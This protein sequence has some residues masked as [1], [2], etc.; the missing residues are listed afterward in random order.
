M[1]KHNNV[2]PFQHFHKKWARRV[3]TWLHQPAQKRIRRERRKLRA[4]AIAPRPAAGALRPLVNCP[5]QKYNSKSR[6]GRGFTLDELK[7]AG[8]DPKYARTVGIAVDSR[9]TNKCGES[10]KLNVDRLQAYKSRLVVVKKGKATADVSQLKG[11]IL[12]SAGKR[13]ALSYVNKSEVDNLREFQGYAA[14]RGARNEARLVGIRE[15][16]AKSE[17]DEKKPAAAAGGDDQ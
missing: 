10:L 12:P 9:R 4:A 5:S 16:Q 15:K 11:D 7:A 14:L 13:T 8:L 6:L 2:I 1:V 3:R 17:K